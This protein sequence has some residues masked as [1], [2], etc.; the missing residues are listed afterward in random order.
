[1]QKVSAYI[2]YYHDYDYLNL[3]LEN[4]S[5]IVDEIIICD[6]PFKYM[7]HDIELL[8]IPTHMSDQ[9]L[10]ALIYSY[11]NIKYYKGV[12]ED[13]FEKRKYSYNKCSNEIVFLIDS[14]EMISIKKSDIEDFEKSDACVGYVSL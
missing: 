3:C 12:F 10:E 9:Q 5:K 8:G 6:G 14:D 13:E 7:M 4:F 2:S 11:K 1:M